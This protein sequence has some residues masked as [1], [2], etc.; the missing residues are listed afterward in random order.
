MDA[1]IAQMGNINNTP[2]LH[3]PHR[4]RL[5]RGDL[6]ERAVRQDRASVQAAGGHLVAAGNVQAAVLAGFS[7]VE[8]KRLKNEERKDL[9]VSK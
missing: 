8:L 3:D 2:A 9:Q 1:L 5:R 6:A 7:Q 4:R